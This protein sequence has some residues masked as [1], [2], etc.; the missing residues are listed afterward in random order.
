MDRVGFE[1]ALLAPPATAAL[2][3]SSLLAAAV[4]SLRASLLVA[5][6]LSFSFAAGSSAVSLPARLP[7]VLLAAGFPSGPL[8]AVRLLTAA[9]RLAAPLPAV[10]AVRPAAPLGVAGARVGV[11]FGVVPLVRAAPRR[12][13]RAS[14]VAGTAA[15]R[16]VEPAALV[17]VSGSPLGLAIPIGSLALVRAVCT[18]VSRSVAV[19]SVVHGCVS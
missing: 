4:R 14:L 2:A 3:L 16:A 7:A 8:S 9:G 19:V 13:V 17:G 6:P 11:G 5:H 10:A 18:S 1:P 15:V 12:A